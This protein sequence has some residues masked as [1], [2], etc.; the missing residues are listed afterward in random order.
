MHAKISLRARCA[1]THDCARNL[2]SPEYH[3]I[4]VVFVYIS[5]YYFDTA[6]F[7]VVA[8]V[9]NFAVGS[10]VAVTAVVFPHYNNFGIYLDFFSISHFCHKVSDILFLLL[11]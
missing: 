3:L 7:A 11:K 8:V 5:F 6:K 4:F 10:V 9:I 1:H 2:S